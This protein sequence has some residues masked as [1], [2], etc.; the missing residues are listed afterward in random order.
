MTSDTRTGRAPEHALAA[1][2]L[3]AASLYALWIL[4][5]WVNPALDPLN[6]YV[7][8]L[9]ARDQPGSTLF[10]TSDAVAGAMA[11]AAAA[12]GGWSE[13][14]LGRWARLGWVGLAVF[15]V[16][17]TVDVTFTPMDCAPYIDSGC[18]LRELVGAVSAAHQIH[19]VTSS[20]AGAGA[21]V[22]MLGLGL[23]TRNGSVG[24]GL[25]WALSWFVITGLATLGTVLALL[26]GPGAGVAQRLQLL[27]ISGWMLVLG[28]HRLR[29]VGVS[30]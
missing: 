22:G 19:A 3:G 9:S 10:R 27:G 20:L 16:A 1:L 21:L 29:T 15:G 8:E 5:T 30:R 11:A 18:A 4:G 13:R 14:A 24:P 12:L 23:A 26:L 25:R 2:L 28:V 17:T 7:S 6:G